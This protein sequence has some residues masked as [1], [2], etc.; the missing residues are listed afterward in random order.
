MNL[1]EL[2]S[3]KE[4]GARQHR[5]RSLLGFQSKRECAALADGAK[6][7]FSAS[8]NARLGRGQAA[9]EFALVL[10]VAMIVLF[11]GIQMAA[12]GQAASA[13][14]QMNYQ[15]A[16]YAAVNTS[17]T[18]SQV[19]SYMQSAGSP[20][21][22]KNGVACTAPGGSGVQVQMTCSPGGTCGAGETRGFGTSVQVSLSFDATSL[23]FLSQ[24]F[25]GVPFPA[26]LT[27]TETIM[28]Q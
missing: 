20:T 27:S 22:T 19:A 18:C 4:G 13:L 11:V 9:V 12:I 21:I 8:G 16:R 24:N 23:M 3:R 26:R 10:P 28:S 5:K 15:G 14:G 25:F 6:G 1:A 7:R 2:M 17:A